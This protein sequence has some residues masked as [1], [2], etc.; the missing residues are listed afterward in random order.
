MKKFF[1]ILQLCLIVLCSCGEDS[2]GDKGMDSSKGFAPGNIIDKTLTLKKDNGNVYLSANHLSSNNVLIDSSDLIDYG[3]YPPSYAY[4]AKENN[5][6]SYHLSVTKKAYI[7][8]YGTYTYATFVFDIE[9]T[10]F[11]ATNGIYQ[12]TQI[13]GE[14]KKTTISGNFTLL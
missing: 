4:S 5:K 8:Y 2:E 3:K 11:S 9:L 6:A 12:G 14:G 1:Y 13:N 10:F 7:P